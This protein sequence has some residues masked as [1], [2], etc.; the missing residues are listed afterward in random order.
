MT[1]L[2]SSAGAKRASV[3]VTPADTARHLHRLAEQ[4]QRKAAL[5]SERLRRLLPQAAVMLRDRY[6]AT[7]V[8]LF[9]SVATGSCRESSDVDMAVRGLPRTLYFEALAGLM[10]LFGTPV[11]LVRLEDAPKSLHERIL[12]EGETL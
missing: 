4:R 8:I 11:D 12:A 5:R 7:D 3:S 2:F 6:Q 9:G 10:V 1:T